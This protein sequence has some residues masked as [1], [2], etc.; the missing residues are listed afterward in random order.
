LT[1]TS[2]LISW[3]SKKQTVVALSTCEAEYMAL[4]ATV[5]EGI[6]HAQLLSHI[7]K[8]CTFEPILIF[9]DTQSVIA[10]SK[11]AGVKRQRAKH[12]DIRY[13]FIR[14]EIINGR[15]IVDYCPTSE[16][17]ADVMTKPSVKFKL[18]K[19]KGFLLV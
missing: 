4:A 6:Y 9:D 14:S 8:E 13:H 12:I 19:F 18:E 7:D 3:K 11:D 10:L 16:M 17:V 2:P 15:V 5:Q 1:K